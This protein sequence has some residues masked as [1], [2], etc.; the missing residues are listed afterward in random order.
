MATVYP[1]ALAVLVWY[2]G[3]ESPR[4]LVLAFYGG[5]FAT[6]ALFGLIGLAL[7]QGTQTVPKHHSGPSAAIDIV[8][9]L[10]MLGTALLL[11]R[12]HG[13]PKEPKKERRRD[14]RGALL[15]GVALYT[16]SLF[17]LSA[18]K[19]LADANAG[20]FP[21]LLAGLVL[22]ICVLLIVEFPLV[23]YLLFPEWTARK[24]KTFDGW[25][26]RY[27]RTLVLAGLTV[28]G[29]YMLGNGIYRA[30]IS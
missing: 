28:G 9:G 4:R 13:S 11:A 21:T 30:V 16:P 29:A 12:R 20:V 26:H 19:Q 8:L 3:L 27:G 14:P 22:V 1:P 23:F 10:A 18:L 7:L 6:T 2:L 15:L 24:L 5:A 25:M 17:Y